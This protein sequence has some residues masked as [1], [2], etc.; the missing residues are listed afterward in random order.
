MIPDKFVMIVICIGLGGFLE[1]DILVLFVFRV[2]VVGSGGW[3]W[4][5]VGRGFVANFSVMMLI[6]V[7][8]IV[9]VC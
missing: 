4:L 3:C 1:R 5:L 2:S 7:S 6:I 8:F 9:V